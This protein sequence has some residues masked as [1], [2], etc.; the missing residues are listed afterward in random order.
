MIID[1]NL[2]IAEYYKNSACLPDKLHLHD[3]RVQVLSNC[4]KY[5]RLHTTICRFPP[6]NTIAA[7]SV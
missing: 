4:L 6:A 7:L 5:R 1:V 3:M 2:L